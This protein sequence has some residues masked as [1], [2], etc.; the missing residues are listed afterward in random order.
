MRAVSK[1]LNL[2]SKLS[3]FALLVA[4]MV[5]SQATTIN[6]SKLS[7]D[8]DYVKISGKTLDACSSDAEKLDCV[9]STGL[10][11]SFATINSKVLS[12]ELTHFSQFNNTL[13]ARG[14]PLV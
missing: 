7:T 4:Y 10:N 1:N 9:I 3:V 13:N 11:V 12:F 8:S 5:C 6:G 2:Q 14:P